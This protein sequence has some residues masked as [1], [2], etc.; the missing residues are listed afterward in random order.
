[1]KLWRYIQGDR[2]GK[3]AHRIEK[4]AM[5][6]P[7]LADALEGFEKVEGDHLRQMELLRKQI[8]RKSS[9]KRTFPLRAWSVAASLL[10]I[11][12]AGTYYIIKDVEMP[13]ALEMDLATVVF[14]EETIPQKTDT[15]QEKVMEAVPAG[16]LAVSASPQAKKQKVAPAP[17]P[18]AEDVIVSVLADEA[19]VEAEEKCE[20]AAVEVTDVYKQ[21]IAAVAAVAPSKENTD[22]KLETKPQALQP[23]LAGAAK[24]K[25]RVT[26]QDGEALTG[27]SIHIRGTNRG[28]VSG[29]DGSFELPANS[30]E[31]IEVQYIGY[32][33]A[34]LA[35]DT[36]QVLYVA[37]QENQDAL[38]E[39][40]VVGYGSRK[41][42]S[43]TPAAQP[44]KGERSY[45]K[46]LQKNM[47][48]PSDECKEVKGEVMLTFA[49]NE[50]GRP[51]DICVVKS[52]CPSADEEAIR[53]VNEGPDWKKSRELAILT[54]EF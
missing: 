49:I 41:K 25:G 43:K 8:A 23:M 26:D 40:V 46:Y 5:Q 19:I 3:E 21:K 17:V 27:A 35:V 20:E 10:I 30:G 50:E 9:K 31:K 18:V 2:K 42:S 22:V 29:V 15:T 1:M 33:P 12:G 51:Y 38:S 34:M 7:F 11:I 44:L 6:D 36:S 28:T 32:D 39:V 37:L 16:A 13:M 24:V 48:R 54:I 53:L 14:E 47:R 45:R 4:E 52:L